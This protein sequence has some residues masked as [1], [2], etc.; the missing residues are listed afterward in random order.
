MG[1]LFIFGKSYQFLE[2]AMDITVRRQGI[3]TNNI[4]N[5]DTIGY[6]PKDLDFKEALRFEVEKKGDHIS[7]THPKHLSTKKTDI[8]REQVR[9]NHDS[10]NIDTEMID[11]AENNLK[12]RFVADRLAGKARKWADVLSKVT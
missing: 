1:D 12:F 9:E 10:V 3:I 11:M 5:M 4:A 8:A 2:K 6:K 7:K